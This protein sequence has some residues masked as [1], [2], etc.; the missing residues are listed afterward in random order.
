LWITN[1]GSARQF[2]TSIRFGVFQYTLLP[3]RYFHGD[4]DPTA[5]HLPV[6][7]DNR[8]RPLFK[9]T[10][11]FRFADGHALDFRGL[12]DRTF[13]SRRRTFADSNQQGGKGFP[14]TYAFA[15]SYGGLIGQFKLDWI[16]VKPFIDDP[17]RTEQSYRFAPH[18]PITMRELND[19]VEDRISDHPPTTVDLP[20]T[21]PTKLV[22]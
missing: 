3:V 9:T 14:P 8:E 17:R 20:L 11:K 10:E 21:E 12:P 15:R 13:P 22:R 19:S 4:N 16:L 7:W 6:L 5:F 1:S 18:F 2:P